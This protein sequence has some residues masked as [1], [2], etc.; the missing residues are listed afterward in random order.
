MDMDINALRSVVT[1]ASFV[2][3]LGIALWTWSSK[4]QHSQHEAAAQLPFLDEDGES[5][6]AAAARFQGSNK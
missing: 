5:V 4:R 3:F 2:L 1:V 6:A